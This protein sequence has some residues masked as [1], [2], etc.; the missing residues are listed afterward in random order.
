[1]NCWKIINFNKEYGITR[2]YLQ[3]FLFGLLA[4]IILYVPLSIKHGTTDMSK[5]GILPFIVMVC[6]LPLIHSFMHILPLIMMNKRARL[7]YKRNT[8]F[9]PIINYYTKKHLTK[10]ASLL[11]AGTPTI[12]ITIP[13]V[14]AA[15]LFSEFYVYFLIFTSAHIA[16]TFT[17]FIYIF[18]IAK[19]PRQS[20]IENRNNEFTILIQNEKKSAG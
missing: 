2:L 19:A 5:S 12:L 11:A 13:G 4:F 16:I 18:Y 10:K 3:S 1:M 14:T 8:I 6:C 7:I 15:Y 9:F 17:D 20:F